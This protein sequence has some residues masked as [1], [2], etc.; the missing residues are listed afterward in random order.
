MRNEPSRGRSNSAAN[1][2]SIWWSALVTS[3][4]SGFSSKVR[5]SRRSTAWRPASIMSSRIRCG[6]QGW[7]SLVSAP[8]ARDGRSIDFK[9]LQDF[10]RK[11]KLQPKS[12]GRMPKP[13]SRERE[14]ER[15]RERGRDGT[16]TGNNPEGRIL[17]KHFQILIEEF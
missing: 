3:E 6:F 7:G 1:M 16:E 5:F 10:G 17:L 4:E 12:P 14:R 13:G 2:A 8:G 15:E 11:V 9:N